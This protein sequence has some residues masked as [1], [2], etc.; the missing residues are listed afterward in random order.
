MDK[1][2]KFLEKKTLEER[3]AAFMNE[4]KAH[5]KDMKK[6]LKEFKKSMQ[7]RQKKH[8]KKI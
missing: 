2:G 1:I 6:S 3:Q 4:L 5:I 8:L 7:N